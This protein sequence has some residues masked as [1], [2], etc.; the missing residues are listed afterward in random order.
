MKESIPRA[1][2]HVGGDIIGPSLLIA[3]PNSVGFVSDTRTSPSS[4][5]NQQA[6]LR[7]RFA[8]KV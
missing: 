1:K 7:G 3:I 6:G 5:P 2:P 8:T 4:T